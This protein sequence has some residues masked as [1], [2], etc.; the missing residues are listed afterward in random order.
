MI[1]LT[2]TNALDHRDAS[3]NPR[4]SAWALHVMN[5]WQWLT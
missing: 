5:Y 2:A 3:L 1:K 4:A